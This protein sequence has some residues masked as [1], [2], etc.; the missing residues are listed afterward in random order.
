MAIMQPQQPYQSPMQPADQPKR[1]IAKTTVF[2]LLV[3]TGVTLF[4]AGGAWVYLA[5]KQSS[6]NGKAPDGAAQVL[7]PIESAPLA[8]TISSDLGM[9]IAYNARELAGFGYSDN[10]TYSGGDLRERRPYS[11]VRL[12]PVE[13]SEATRSEIAAGS[14]ELRITS[15]LDKEYWQQMGDDPL[16]KD[17]SKI[18]QLV[19]QTNEQ[20]T[21][22][23]NVTASEASIVQVGGTEYRKVSYTNKNE[24]LGVTTTQRED[25]YMTVVNERPYVACINNIRS[26]NFAVVPQLESVLS[27]MKFSAPDDSALIAQKDQAAA[28]DQTMLDSEKDEDVSDRTEEVIESTESE[29]EVAEVK[30]DSEEKHDNTSKY[31]E[32]SSDLRSFARAAPATVRVGMIYCADLNLSLPNGAAGPQL[33][34]ACVDRAGSGFFISHEGLL[35]TAASTVQVSPQDAIRSYIVDAPTLDQMYSRLDRVLGYLVESRSLMQSDADAIRTGIEERN[36]DVIDKVS[37]LSG[38]VA[39]ENISISK[40]EYKYALQLSDKPIVINTQGDGSLGFAYSDQVIEAE[41]VAQKLTDGKTRDQVQ[42]GEFPE[43]DVALLKAKKAGAY[44][45]LSLANSTNVSS[46]TNINIIGLPQFAT[47]SLRTA[48]MRP[49]HMLR[50]G[51]AGEIFN[52]VASQRLLSIKTS[53]HAGLI[54]APALNGSAQVVGVATYGNLNCPAGKCFAGTILRDLVDVRALIRERNISLSP[55]SPVNE[56]WAMAV[57][58]MIKGNYQQAHDLFN[59]SAS[60]YPANYLATP[61]ANYTKAKLG[62][63]TDTS[64]INSWMR[65]AQLITITAIVVL[66]LLVIIRLAMKLFTRPQPQ[67]QYG[68]LSNGQ[69]I[70]PTQWQQNSAQPGNIPPAQPWTSAE[71]YYQQNSA[72]STPQSPS[73]QPPYAGQ[74]PA[75]T[76][77]PQS[78]NPQPPQQPPYS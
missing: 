31:L 14:P 71:N 33:T 16:F 47:G 73:S 63:S 28:A 32:S 55:S 72:P 4:I 20:R 30:S 54:G 2:V 25:C 77:T 57:D 6:D 46:G 45:A 3:V 43:H 40:E 59:Q 7:E 35:T 10:V 34:G 51:E 27:T 58:E 5:T 22:D 70:D 60:L 66:I 52:G 36:Q 49:T 42:K 18:D 41:L 23:R 1:N 15:S 21:T 50:Q 74:Y 17:L 64:A 37:A 61:Y 67:T 69:Y 19:K 8:A 65:L 24:S 13:T 11:V 78:Q 26:S 44:P 29:R 9:H 12:R 75:S 62:S 53:S 56:T 39:T 76:P 48:Q 38:L 68:Q